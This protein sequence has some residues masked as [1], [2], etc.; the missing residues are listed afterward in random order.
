M[1]EKLKQWQKYIKDRLN[2]Y[3]F[4]K[5]KKWKIRELK[6]SYLQVRGWTYDCTLQNRISWQGES[7][8]IGEVEVAFDFQMMRNLEEAKEAKERE[9]KAL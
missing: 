9:E 7:F 8:K 1:I 3:E 5:Y 4:E 6:I 2:K